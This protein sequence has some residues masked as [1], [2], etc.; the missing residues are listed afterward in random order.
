M[1]IGVE[2]AQLA[3]DRALPT[4]DVPLTFQVGMVGSDGILLASDLKRTHVGM[5]RGIYRT[6]SNQQKI[7]IEGHVAYCSSGDD[8]AEVAAQTFCAQAASGFVGD[9]EIHRRL[10]ASAQEALTKEK[11]AKPNGLLSRRGGSVL[12]ALRTAD[13]RFQLWCLDVIGLA[14]TAQRVLNRIING[15]WG[16]AAGF[17]IERYFPERRRPIQELRLLA[18]HTV[19]VAGRL[20]PAGVGGLEIVRCSSAGFEKLGEDEIAALTE[21]SMRLD[22]DIGASLGV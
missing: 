21:A 3:N 10:V 1:Q 2:S 12:F 5:L 6:S 11:G 22:E 16:N 18:A 7:H 13:G 14:P 19:L 17:F 20:N 8:L 9:S 4:E 15:D